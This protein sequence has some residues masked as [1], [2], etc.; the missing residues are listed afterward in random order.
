MFIFHCLKTFAVFFKFLSYSLM[1]FEKEGLFE[2]LWLHLTIWCSNLLYNN[3]NTNQ[4][5]DTIYIYVYINM[6]MVF[7]LQVQVF[8]EQQKNQ[9]LFAQQDNKMLHVRKI[10]K[11]LKSWI[12]KLNNTRNATSHAEFMKWNWAGHEVKTQNDKWLLKNVIV[13]V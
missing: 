9:T 4:T 11:K 6:Y 10:I 12:R 7:R 13:E 5:W 1:L 2:F 8:K 3:I